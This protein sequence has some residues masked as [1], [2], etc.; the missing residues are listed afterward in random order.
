MKKLLSLAAAGLMMTG[1]ASTLDK[2]ENVGKE[3]PL[4]SVENPHISPEYQP[5]TWPLPD[6]EPER[7]LYS[8]SLWQPGA[9]AFFRDQRAN[10]VGDILRVKVAID[11]KAEVD[12]ETKRD[13]ENEQEVALPVIGQLGRYVLPEIDPLYSLSGNNSTTGKG[14]IKREDKIETTVAAVITQLLPNGNMVISGSQE[15]RVNHEV[16][17]LS[18]KG[19]VRPQDIDSDNTIDSSQIA[20]ARIVYGGRGNISDLQAPRWGH[21]ILDIVAPF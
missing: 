20:E 10:R 2:L 16:R 5:M 13:R 7:Q 4:T 11:D 21:Q 1:C 8:N 19:I 3:P 18:I 9:R 15:I 6:P 14:E 17:E 12:N